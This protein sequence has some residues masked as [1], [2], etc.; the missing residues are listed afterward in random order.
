[1]P[2]TARL[3]GRVEDD[4]GPPRRARDDVGVADVSLDGGH[5]ERVELGVCATS[6]H[7]HL[8]TARAEGT[9]EVD[10]EKTTATRHERDRRLTRLGHVPPPSE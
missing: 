5:A 7:P 8:V 9:H 1:M 4:V 2:P 6:E 10:A 3:C